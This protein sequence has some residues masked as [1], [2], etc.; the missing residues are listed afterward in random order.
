MRNQ[1]QNLDGNKQNNFFKFNTKNDKMGIFGNAMGGFKSQDSK[2]H[3]NKLE[4][5]IEIKSIYPDKIKEQILKEAAEAG[6]LP[7][8][9]KNNNE[10]KN[11]IRKNEQE[12]DEKYI[13]SA[14]KRLEELEKIVGFGEHGMIGYGPGDKSEYTK[15]NHLYSIALSS[16]GDIQ[17]AKQVLE[18]TLR[19]VPLGPHGMI[20]YKPG[21]EYEFTFNNLLYSIA[22]SNTGDVQ[23]AEQ[24]M[25]NTLKNVPLGEHGM[26]GDEP[27]YKDEYTKNNL[28]YSIALSN[29]G[30]IQ[31]SKHVLENTLKHVPFG[32]HGRIGYGP[33]DK[34]E[35]TDNNLLYSI[36]LSFIGNHQE[37]KQVME[38]TLRNVPFGPHGMIIGRRPNSECTRDSLLLIIAE[39]LIRKAGE[40]NK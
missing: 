3:Q 6:L 35:Y 19:N 18:N 4:Q 9:S 10:I 33:G 2:K 30:G 38:N 27:G 12:K 37:A 5:N 22:L 26:I 25:E 21:D 34:D 7:K 11:S 29:T 15:E 8:E 13:E 23:K 40:I 14:K 39:V 20:G 31:K 36:A 32:P 16:L 17:E 28:L 24:V 1:D